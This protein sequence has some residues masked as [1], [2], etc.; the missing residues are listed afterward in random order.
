MN[1]EIESKD[2]VLR[3]GKNDP[4]PTVRGRAV[5]NATPPLPRPPV[6][7]LLLEPRVRYAETQALLFRCCR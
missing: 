1:P 2:E 7:H 6:E 3:N 4:S 5:V